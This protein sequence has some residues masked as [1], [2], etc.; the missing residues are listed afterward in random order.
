MKRNVHEI[1]DELAATSSKND[2]V[3]ILQRE[4]RNTLLQLVFKM[5]L[6]N[7]LQFYT[8][9][10]PE[11]AKNAKGTITFNTALKELSKLSER[12][13]TGNAAQAHLQRLLEGLLPEE[14][15][16][17][18]RVVLKDMRCGVAASTC[19]KAW[20]DD[21]LPEFLV[22]LCQ[23]YSEKNL[24]A[25]NY[26]AIIQEKCDGMR[27]N[28]VVRKK[29]IDVFSRNGKPLELL[30][31]LEK[32]LFAIAGGQ[33]VV[34]DGEL[35]VVDKAGKIL[36]RKAGNGILNKANKGTI[37]PEEASRVR[38]IAWD[39]IPVSAWK[40]GFYA[41]PYVERFDYLQERIR[42]TG[43]REM[44]GWPETERVSGYKEAARF[45]TGMLKQGKEGAVIK[46]LKSPWENARSKQ[47]VKMKVE[48]EVELLVVDREEGSGKNQGKL[49]ALVCESS[50]GL[51]RVNV[52]S[53]LSDKQR[54]EFW[55]DDII[56]KV[57]TVK[58]NDVIDAEGRK[59]KALF[60]PRFVEIREDKDEAETILEIIEKFTHS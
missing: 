39:I 22:M 13:V 60:L 14:R 15:E 58:A 1:I 12:V 40:T 7:Q 33:E 25:I 34:I 10:V 4:G 47:Q 35:L 3:A 18:K 44:I 5:A 23:S 24:Q 26:P 55:G 30:G 32:E 49:G 19:N 27:V 45:Y 59:T 42:D 46:N 28:F 41:T 17:L 31:A 36:P 53:G 2:K 43:T 21:F 48:N 11:I 51:L 20:G 29:R 38:V 16:T 6:D 50:D 37:S 54:V 8:K 56:G 9:K 57:V 52:G